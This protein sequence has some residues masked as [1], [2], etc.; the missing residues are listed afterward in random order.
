MIRKCDHS[1]YPLPDPNTPV[2]IVLD[3][4]SLFQ[5]I[6]LLR[7]DRHFTSTTTFITS[8]TQRQ[9]GNYCFWPTS[10]LPRGMRACTT[11]STTT[12]STTARLAQA[13]RE[14]HLVPFFGCGVRC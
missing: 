7:H 3:H 11:A 13:D 4:M 2:A 1:S 10:P 5:E 6:H 8:R 14:A 12:R 9:P